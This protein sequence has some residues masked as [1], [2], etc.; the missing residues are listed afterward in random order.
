MYPWPASPISSL[1]PRILAILHFLGVWH[2]LF[3]LQFFI[4]LTAAWHLGQMSPPQ[5]SLPW[6]PQPF[7]LPLPPHFPH[8]A[9]YFKHD[10]IYFLLTGLFM[11]SSR[12]QNKPWK[13]SP[14]LCSLPLCPWCQAHGRCQV[15][16]HGINGWVNDCLLTSIFVKPGTVPSVE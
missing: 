2:L 7:P 13:Q 11:S 1:Y 6:S 12:L 4:Q 10:L 16:I 9:W 5:R 15:S 3:C 14:C 8:S